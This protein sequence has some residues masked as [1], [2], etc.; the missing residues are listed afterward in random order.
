MKICE[1]L[2]CWLR[3]GVAQKQW[4]HGHCTVLLLSLLLLLRLLPCHIAG[5]RLRGQACGR[6]C[7]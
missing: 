1:A 7:P 5:Q 2:E 3:A 6:E 4:R